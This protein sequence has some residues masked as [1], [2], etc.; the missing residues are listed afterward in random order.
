MSN[1]EKLTKVGINW[2]KPTYGKPL[3]KPYK[4]RHLIQFLFTLFEEKIIKKFKK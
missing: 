1:E 4:L 2:Y 3:T